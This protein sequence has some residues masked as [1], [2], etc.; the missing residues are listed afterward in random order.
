MKYM[1]VSLLFLNKVGKNDYYCLGIENL[2]EKYKL[3]TR[4]L[5][6]YK[7][8]DSDIIKI[9]SGFANTITLTQSGKVY[10]HGYGYHG[11]LAMKNNTEIQKPTQIVYFKSI[12]IKDVCCKLFHSIFM[13]FQNQVY[14]CGDSGDGSFGEDCNG[15]IIL[16]RV[17]TLSHISHMALTD[18]ESFFI[19]KD[20]CVSYGKK[21]GYFNSLKIKN[22]FVYTLTCGPSHGIIVINNVNP[23]FTLTTLVNRKKFIDVNFSFK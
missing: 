17:L 23:Y 5:G 1:V 22:D 15:W 4:V 13:D 18:H 14:F 21:T 12:P 2:K 11:E 10:G 16:P 9:T 20:G 7:K 3:P 8:L 19:T 6:D